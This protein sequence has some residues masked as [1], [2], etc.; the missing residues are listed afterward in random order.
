MDVWTN[1]YELAHGKKPR[2]CGWWFFEN[3]DRQ[4]TYDGW[5]SYIDVKREA[6]KAAKAAGIKVIYAGS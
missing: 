4:W 2:G 1:R 5:G 3:F 6:M